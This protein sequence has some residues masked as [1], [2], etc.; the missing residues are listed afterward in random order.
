MTDNF[1]EKKIFLKL[2][3]EMLDILKILRYYCKGF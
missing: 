3:E 1:F 2:K